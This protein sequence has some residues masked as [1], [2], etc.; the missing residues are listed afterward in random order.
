MQMSTHEMEGCLY[1][2]K[3]I[4]YKWTRSVQT[5]FFKDVCCVQVAAKN[6]GK[7][8]SVKG[9]ILTGTYLEWEFFFSNEILS[10]SE[11]N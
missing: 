11:K 10:V 8:L 3:D 6:P 9:K 1:L 2:L 4:Q 7:Q 5:M